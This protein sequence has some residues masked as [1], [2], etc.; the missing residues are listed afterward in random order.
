MS[1]S[2]IVM[3][4]ATSGFGLVASGRLA[5]EP[6]RLIVGTRS[7][8]M[9][10]AEAVD[11]ADLASVRRFAASV[12]AR[13]HGGPID[14][15]V[16]NA[17]LVLPD[18]THRT[19]D[20]FETT[21]AVNHLAHALLLRELGSSLAEGGTVVMT[22]SGTHDPSTGASLRTPRHA[23]A[24][25]LAHPDRDPGRDPKPA[26]AA[27]HAYTASKLCVVLT[28]RRFARDFAGTVIAYDPGQ[29]FGTQLAVSL[30]AR[31]RLAWSVM[32]HPAVSWLP[33]RFS[34]TLN[35]IDDAG[36]ALADLALA[37]ERPP[38]G[39]HYAALRRGRLEWIPP[40][41]LAQ[42][43]AVEEAL[44]QETGLLLGERP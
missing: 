2:T 12:R 17:G 18:D 40:S 10:D 41:E 14:A 20:G 31:M 13:L 28:A 8:G 38:P 35:T 34:P 21:F 33:R 5:A 25:L 39:E 3:T 11:L 29:V 22:T 16:L 32:G 44:W 7:P 30:P 27:E 24:A 1:A 36:N 15:L 23:D 37:V 4:G 26:K 19:V 43:P 9:A 6:H 42:D